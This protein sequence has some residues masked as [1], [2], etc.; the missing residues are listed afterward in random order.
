[1][2]FSIFRY[3]YLKNENFRK[4]F[5]KLNFNGKEILSINIRIYIHTVNWLKRNLIVSDYCKDQ[6]ESVKM[7]RN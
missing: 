5:Y 3:I 2:S 4:I 7:F 6:L 1:M